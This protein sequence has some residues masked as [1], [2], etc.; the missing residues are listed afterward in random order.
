MD[1]KVVSVASEPVSPSGPAAS[2]R[3]FRIHED[4]VLLRQVVAE[5]QIFMKLVTSESWQKVSANLS[6]ACP[7]IAG[8]KCV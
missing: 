5:K 8:I 2:C 1:V 3:K 7:R 6:E 4:L